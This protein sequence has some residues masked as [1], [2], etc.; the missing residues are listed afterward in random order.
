MTDPFV[1]WIPQEEPDVVPTGP[2]AGLR[3]AVKDL[4]DVAGMPTGA[5]NPRWLE[6]HDVPDADAAAVARLRAA[7]AGLVGKTITDELAWSLNGT[8]AH[9]G[10]PDNPAAPGRMPGG[11][12]SGSASAVALGLADIGLGTDTGGSIRVPAS[13]CGLFGLRPTHGRVPLDGV[14]PLSASFDTAGVLTRDA[15]TLRKASEVLLGSRRGPRAV[16]KLLVPR[17]I[18]NATNEDTRSA[19]MPAV[20]R[21]GLAVD[22]TPLFEDVGELE[23]ARVTYATIQAFE[24]WRTHREWIEE[25]SPE[26]GPGVAARFAAA[27]K[28]TEGDVERA[29][30]HRRR[31]ADLLG[32]RLGDGVALA[33]PAAPSPAPKLDDQPDREAVVRLTCMAGLSG[34]P[35]VALPVGDVAGLPVGLQ[36]VAAPGGD[37]DLLALADQA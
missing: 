22:R 31:V 19:L 8:N 6:T 9:Y 11:S 18:W 30:R 33:V 20:E 2:L 24:A 13:Y 32:D 3:L 17:D 35:A 34:A 7:G 12:S 16:T 21:F 5:G 27:A 4:F 10:T 1:T 37:E 15:A 14:V 28:L 26:F 25:A 23:A 36:L 29:A